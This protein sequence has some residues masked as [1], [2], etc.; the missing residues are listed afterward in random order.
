[1]RICATAKASP[2]AASIRHVDNRT[3]KRLQSC[4]KV[5]D[6]ILRKYPSD[7]ASAEFDAAWLQYKLTAK[8]TP[9]QYAESILIKSGKVDNVWDKRTLDNASREELDFLTCRSF[10]NY[11]AQNPRSNTEHN[12]FIADSLLSIENVGGITLKFNQNTTNKE[13]P[14]AETSGVN[15]LRVKILNQIPPLQLPFVAHDIDPLQNQCYTFIQW[16]VVTL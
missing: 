10:S 1:M 12:T 5:V 6:F 16:T 8:M 14:T 9:H 2:T 7:R 15:H 11:W 4:S 13:S 3:C